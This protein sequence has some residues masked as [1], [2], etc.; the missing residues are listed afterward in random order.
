MMDQLR[1]RL[2]FSAPPPKP[3]TITIAIG[4]EQALSTEL[5]PGRYTVGGSPISDFCIHTLR[6]DRLCTIE[7]LQRPDADVLIIHDPAPGLRL[8]GERIAGSIE[9]DIDGVTRLAYGDVVIELRAERA[10]PKLIPYM[11]MGGALVL[12]IV[13]LGLD[14]GL[15]RP[16]LNVEAPVMAPKPG[17][18]ASRTAVIEELRRRLT[19]A[20]LISRIQL[21]DEPRGVVATGTLPRSHTA[22]WRE[23]LTEVRARSTVPLIADI[24]PVPEEAD[25]RAEIAGVMLEPH[26]FVMGQDG[27]ARNEGEELPS[28]WRIEAISTN[29]V[30][31]AR[32][33]LTDRIRLPGAG[34]SATETPGG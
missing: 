17:S 11:L 22:R 23:I 28:G 7:L 19:Q 25:G 29:D 13:G 30:T 34:L 6:D 3:P 27:R 33:G 5:A 26:R 12:L 16:P 31:L 9:T 2:P 20:D 1:Q 24:A 32:D 4:G 14:S 10:A 18:L 21:A 8:D 15:P